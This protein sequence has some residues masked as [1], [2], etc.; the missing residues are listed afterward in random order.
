MFFLLGD[1][2]LVVGVFGFFCVRWRGK[3]GGSDMLGWRCGK[4]IGGG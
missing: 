1:G 2:G 4:V 3:G